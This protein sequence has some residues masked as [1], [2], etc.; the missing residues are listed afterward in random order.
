VPVAVTSLD[1]FSRWARGDGL[2]IVLLVLGSVLLTR[3]VPWFS[4][5]LTAR[6][7]AADEQSDAVVRS[8][9]AKH[10]H[11]L[12]QAITW[13]VVALIYAVTAVLVLD[14]FGVPLATLIAPATV[15]GVALGFGAQRIVQ[16][17][18]AGFFII[19]ERQYGYGDL[20]R[21]ANLGATSGVTGTVEDV[22]LR[23]TRMRTVNGEVVFIPNGQINQ[24]TNLSRDWA[25]AIVD[26]PLP[27]TADIDQVNDLLQRVG[28]Q[29]YADPQLRP[30]ILDAPTVM[31]V[32]TIDVDHLSI[33]MVSRTLPG[34]QF[35]VGRELRA[36]V[37]TALRE[38]GIV[39]MPD[40]ESTHGAAPH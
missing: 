37:A 29:L 22:T 8:E 36:R 23:T 30:L 38:A 12:A 17:I 35:V 4:T 40:V 15:A 24:V 16:D 9:A 3:A 11:S 28:Q 6:V 25:R 21:I 18:L 13:A 20:I 27:A 32:E 39:T 1:D 19:A 26:V 34:K 7:D 5:R 14:R 2:E 33:R 10:R 31:G